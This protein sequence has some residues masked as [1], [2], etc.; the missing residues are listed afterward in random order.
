[1]LEFFL[2][3]PAQKQNYTYTLKILYVLNDYMDICAAKKKQARSN[4]S[5]YIDAAAVEVE[6]IEYPNTQPVALMHLL[7]HGSIIKKKH[8]RTKL[9]FCLLFQGY[10]L[11]KTKFRT[12]LN[13]KRNLRNR[14]Q[15][16][17]M[18]LRKIYFK[19]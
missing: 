13:I 10:F 3:N 11:C 7:L 16:H 4:I 6:V 18:V 14:R 9:T 17:A 12:E 2:L 8:H 1:M 5:A 19:G 15:M